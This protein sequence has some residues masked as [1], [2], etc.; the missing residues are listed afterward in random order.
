M[1]VIGALLVLSFP[2]GFPFGLARA[3]LGAYTIWTLWSAKSDGY[4]MK[5]TRPSD[6]GI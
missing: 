3:A 2:F 1:L 6:L 5:Y 4:F